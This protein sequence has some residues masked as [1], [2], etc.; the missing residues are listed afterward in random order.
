MA[1]ATGGKSVARS[2]V[3]PE[4]TLTPHGGDLVEFDAIVDVDA[5]ERLAVVLEL[6]WNTVSGS[7]AG[8]SARVQLILDA[9]A[10]ARLAV[11]LAARAEQLR[12]SG[13]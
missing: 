1:R 12:R 5:R 2:R 3:R 9:E 8:A 13:P 10:A 7:A 6:A 4:R 11:L